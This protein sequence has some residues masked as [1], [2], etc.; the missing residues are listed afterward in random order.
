[1]NFN[2][3]NLFDNMDDA[4]REDHTYFPLAKKKTPEHQALCAKLEKPFHRE[5]C[6]TLDWSDDVLQVKL[7]NIAQIILGVEGH[8]PDILVLQEVENDRILGRLNKDFLS[9]AGYQT[10]VLLEGPDERGI[11]IAVLSRFPQAGKPVLHKI[12]YAAKNDSDKKWMAKSRGILEVK[13]QL[14]NKET[15]TVFGVHFPSQANPRY[16][17]E[18]A[19][20]AL[21]Q[22][23]QEQ[24]AQGPV[25]ASG[26]FNITRVEEQETRFFG[27][28]FSSVSMVSHLVGCKTCEGT[29]NYRRDWSFLDV[30][31][32]SKNLGPDGNSGYELKTDSITVIRKDPLHLWG[33]YPKRFKPEKKEGVSDHFPLYARL[34][35]RKK[36]PKASSPQN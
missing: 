15:L 17:R 29:H 30:M 8:G 4:D 6:L 2:V 35:L 33:D 10:Q 12:P 32:F 28:K 14:P 36:T 3:E 16:W 13:L 26:D 11:D 1:M 18:Q 34:G 24:A 27:E 21:S 31:L 7:Q 5:E 23:I 9:K 19:V 25:V 22:L 20:T